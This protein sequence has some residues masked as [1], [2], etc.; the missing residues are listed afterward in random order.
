MKVSRIGLISKKITNIDEML[1]V[2]DILLQ[3]GQIMQ[4]GSGIYA[5]GHIPYLVK[6]NIEIVISKTLTKYGCSE[7]SL[8]VL[9][10]ESIW[11][12]SGNVL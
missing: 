5:Y 4:F 1:P 2:Q 11:E 8:P 3:T 12:K 7:L 6:K 10:P 9:Q